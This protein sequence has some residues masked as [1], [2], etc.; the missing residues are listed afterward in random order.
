MAEPGDQKRVPELCSCPIV[1]LVC[2][3]CR[4][5][6]PQLPEYLKLVFKVP[7]FG[8]TLASVSPLAYFHTSHPI[9]FSPCLYS[10]LSCLS[11]ISVPSCVHMTSSIVLS[12]TL[13]PCPCHLRS[14]SDPLCASVLFSVSSSPSLLL[15]LLLCHS[16]I[17]F[18]LHDHST[19]TLGARD[20]RVTKSPRVTGVNEGR[21]G[22]SQT[23]VVRAQ[24][25]TCLLP[26]RP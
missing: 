13:S 1:F 25:P 5:Q 16:A 20:D 12:P 7:S 2:F 8:D 22:P 23:G 24:L 4:F 19:H 15:P 6:C 11:P 26:P 3:L 18:A 10:P 14:Q 17:V 9:L 21:E